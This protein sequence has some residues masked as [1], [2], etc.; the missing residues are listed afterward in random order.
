MSAGSPRRFPTQRQMKVLQEFLADPKVAQY[1]EQPFTVD[2]QHDIPDLAGYSTD[3]RTIFIDRHLAEDK[4]EIAGAPYDQ[5]SQ[6]LVGK[7]GHEHV[8]KAA[9]NIGHRYE[10]AHEDYATPAEHLVLI[11]LGIDPA[12]YE[13]ALRPYIKRAELERVE[14]PPPDLDISPY[15]ED[16]DANDIRVLQRLRELGVEAAQQRF[17]KMAHQA[18]HYGPG[19][20]KEH[21][22]NCE[23]YLGNECELVQNPIT[24]QG[25]CRLWAATGEPT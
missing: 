21:C 20:K 1:L 17:A 23:H 25:W 18:A 4:P 2:D 13:K 16:P 9:L 10:G 7:M 8:E 5:W 11:R 24:S 15:A 12:E 3:G 14:Q 6:A 22:G 19:T